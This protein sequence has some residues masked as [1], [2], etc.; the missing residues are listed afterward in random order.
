MSDHDAACR[1]DRRPP[2]I[3]PAEWRL[4]DGTTLRG[5]QTG[6]GDA[7]LILLHEPGRDLDA[8][9]DLPL[10]LAARSFAVETIDLPGHGLSDGPWQPDALPALVRS[11]VRC[12][13]AT[14][15]GAEPEGLDATFRAAGLHRPVDAQESARTATYLLAAGDSADAALA[16]AADGGVDGLVLLSP[17]PDAAAN[18]RRSGVPKL[19]VTGSQAG[20]ARRATTAL[21]QEAGGWTMLS[22][23]PE[24][25]GGTALVAG[26]WGDQ[27]QEQIVT[28]LRDCQVRWRSAVPTPDGGRQR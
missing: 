12:D 21:A 17:T 1:A 23:I 26:D 20:A 3:V 11:L 25:A 13:G 28:F 16:A 8:W 9:G 15:S 27:V 14:M 2:H 10:L 5:Q 6:R 19:I 22:T 18:R 24:A 7:R 4:A